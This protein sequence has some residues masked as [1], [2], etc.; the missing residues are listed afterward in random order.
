MQRY[1]VAETVLQ[2]LVF[3][4]SQAAASAAKL[5]WLVGFPPKSIYASSE[6]CTPRAAA[7]F[8]S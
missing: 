7:F 5:V 8:P 1:Q 4:A 3:N 2:Y 6:L